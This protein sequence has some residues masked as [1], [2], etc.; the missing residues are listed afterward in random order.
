MAHV[1][2]ELGL[3]ARR[4]FSNFFGLSQFLFRAFAFGNILQKANRADGVALF[5]TDFN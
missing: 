4:G 3:C 1:G 2:K 5:I